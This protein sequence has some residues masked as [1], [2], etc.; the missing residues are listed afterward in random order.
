MDGLHAY[1]EWAFQSV[2]NAAD[3]ALDAFAEMRKK[4]R[5]P[6]TERAKELIGKL[7]KL[8]PARG[9]ERS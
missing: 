4:L 6:L 5:K 8:T 7:E 1:K 2:E 9:S 3:D